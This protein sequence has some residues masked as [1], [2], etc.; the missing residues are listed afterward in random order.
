MWNNLLG[1]I[2]LTLRTDKANYKV[3]DVP[4]FILQ[5]GIPGD[6]IVWT[7]L[8]NGIR[9]G[10]YNSGYGSVI[11]ANGA[12]ELPASGPWTDADVGQWQKIATIINPDGSVA[13]YASVS[14]SVSPAT[15]PAPSPVGTTSGDFF[16]GNMTLPIIGTV[17][18]PVGFAAIGL[19]I[20]GVSQLL[21]KRGR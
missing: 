10:E 5:N 14:F 17:S 18:K 15:A 1:A 16:S 20:F 9:T 6:Q 12:A 21:G 8:K 3:G 13:D 19:T 11:G 2:G 7:S 4:T